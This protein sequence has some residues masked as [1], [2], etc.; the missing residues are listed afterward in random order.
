MENK[1]T[2]YFKYAIGEIVLVVI[3][4]LI[5]LQINNWNENRKEKQK[6]KASLQKFLDDLKAD[7]IN[8]ESNLTIMKNIDTLHTQLFSYSQK[9]DSS[10]T[11]KYPTYIRRALVYIPTA[12]ENDP[13]IVNKISQQIIREEIQ[14]YFR[15]MNLVLDGKN[16]FED[17]IYKIREFIRIKKMHRVKAWFESGR[18]FNITNTIQKEIINQNDLFMLAKDPDFQQLLFESN[19]K[20]NETKD[21]LEKLILSNKNLI[22]LIEGY[23]TN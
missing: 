1:T 6:E 4:I 23:I 20:L 16:E 18:N 10:I 22:K 14:N 21:A 3:G 13:E 12:R 17:V 5:A 2:K 11:L 7:A 15:S 8:F 9:S 19:L